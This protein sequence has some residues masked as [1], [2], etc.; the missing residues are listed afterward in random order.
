MSPSFKPSERLLSEIVF[1]LYKQGCLH[2]DPK[3]FG[4][5]S[6]ILWSIYEST[7]K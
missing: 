3:D 6:D 2:V 4:K 5:K 1:E 7:T